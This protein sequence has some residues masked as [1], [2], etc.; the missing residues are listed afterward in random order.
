M[1][2]LM[3]HESCECFSGGGLDVLWRNSLKRSCDTAH[4]N[5][6]TQITGTSEN[7]F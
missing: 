5:D 2:S 6:R 3:F 7:D 1:N 4:G